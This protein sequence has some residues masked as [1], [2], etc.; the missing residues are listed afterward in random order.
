MRVTI[1]VVTCRA[2]ME[3]EA[4]LGYLAA[5]DRVAFDVGAIDTG[6]KSLVNTAQYEDAVFLVE[7]NVAVV[8]LYLPSLRQ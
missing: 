2:E 5:L 3:R 8:A 4:L 6:L 7:C 1:L